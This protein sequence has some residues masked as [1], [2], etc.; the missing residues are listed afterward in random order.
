MSYLVILTSYG[1]VRWKA[2]SNAYKVMF[3][4]GLLISMFTKWIR[5]GYKKK[6]KKLN[7][8]AHFKFKFKRDLEW[9]GRIARF[10][11]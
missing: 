1:G 8:I 3:H 10:Q 5:T 2:D 6:I 7:I 4:E 11:V 9:V